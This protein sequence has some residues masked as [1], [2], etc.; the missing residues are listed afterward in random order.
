MSLSPRDAGRPRAR[1]AR[2]SGA[3]PLIPD[4]LD[5]VLVLLR[6]GETEFIVDKRFQGQMEAPLTS[7]GQLQARL[8]GL[9]LANP[10]RDPPLP[11]PDAAPFAIVH[12]PLVRTRRTAE[13]VV[14]ALTAAGVATPPLFPE[15]G[16]SEIAQGQ[17]EGLTETEIEARFGDSLAG[18]RRWP[19]RFYAPGGESLDQVT[20]RVEVALA[21]LLGD[22]AAGAE[23]GTHDRN[24]VL[25]YEDESADTRRWALVVGHGGVFRV[26]T[27]LLLGLPLEHF[28]NFD[29]GLP[30]ISVVE[31]RAGR[32]VLRALNLDAH[33]GAEAQRIAAEASKRNAAGAL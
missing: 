33:L 3:A 26:V 21:R 2:A 9:R 10:H 1:E 8:A 13:Y 23:P 29:F 12:S 20:G 24:Q 18:W 19:T 30:A 22:L 6:H 14:E 5:A 28:W 11:I 31:I 32:A 17:W 27:C 15:P 25:G 4:G 7:A 16:L